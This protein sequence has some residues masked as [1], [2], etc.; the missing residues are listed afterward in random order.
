VYLCDDGND[1]K[2]AEYV[3]SLAEAGAIYITGRK[4]EPGQI[5]GK[6]CNLN[7]ALCNVIYAGYSGASSV[8]AAVGDDDTAVIPGQGGA[9]SPPEIPATEVVVVFDADMA[10]KPG[11]FRHV[12]EVLWDDSVGLVLTP[13]AFNNICPGTDIWNNINP[14]VRQHSTTEPKF[15]PVRLQLL[16]WHTTMMTATSWACTTHPHRA[17]KV[18]VID[19]QSISTPLSPPL[20]YEFDSFLRSSCRAV[21]HL[22]MLRAQVGSYQ[23]LP[24]LLAP[25]LGQRYTD[26]QIRWSGGGK[27]IAK[28]EK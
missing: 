20:T 25:F 2:K 27:C 24:Q 10:A 4:R 17:A 9:A 1:P 22:A 19:P 11:F 13:Q 8:H 16:E 5:N 28:P 14:Q 7:N 21:M 12:L 18:T 23:C 15:S 6:A 3:A 26:R